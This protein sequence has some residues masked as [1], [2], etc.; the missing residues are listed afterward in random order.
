MQLPV[1]QRRVDAFGDLVHGD[2]A[3]WMLFRRERVALFVGEE[4]GVDGDRADEVVFVGWDG[5]VGAVAD[6]DVGG[7]RGFLV[8]LVCPEI[9]EGVA[10]TRG[11]E[12]CPHPCRC[13]GVDGG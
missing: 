11:V 13:C 1:Q 6:C 5:D 10:G 12:V 2:V 7:R 3:V 4:L 9:G 8:V